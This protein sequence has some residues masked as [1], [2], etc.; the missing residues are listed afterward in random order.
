METSDVSYNSYS[1]R[2]NRFYTYILFSLRDKGLYI[3][4]TTNLKYRLLEYGKGRVTTT[5]NRNPLYLIFYEYFVNKADAKARE[6]FL[7]SGFGRKQLAKA[8]QHIL[9]TLIS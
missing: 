4:Y 5:K 6:K 9:T 2:N 1:S 3:G 7:K 8:L